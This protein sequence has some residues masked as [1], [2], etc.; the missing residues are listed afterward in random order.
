MPG[1]L[2][3]DVQLAVVPHAQTHLIVVGTTVRKPANIV[4]A[5][6][7]SLAWQVKPAQVELTYAFVDDGSPPDTRALLNAFVAEHGGVVWDAEPAPQQDF[8]DTGSTHQWTHQA[9]ARVGRSKDRILDW[10]RHQRAEAVWFC[11]SDLICDPMT[12]V[13]L[14]SV[15]EPIVAAVYWTRWEQ[16]PPEHPVVH[17]GPQV[18]LTHPYNLNGLGMEEWEFRRLLVNRQVVEVLG[19]GACTLIRRSALMKGVSFA[20]WPGNTMEGIGQ[21]EDRHFNLRA[22]ALHLKQ[23]ADPWPDIFHIYHR[24][25]DEQRIP[26][27]L[28][29]LARYEAR[30]TATPT[31]ETVPSVGDLVSLDL[32]ALEPVQTPNGLMHP[33]TRQVRGR[34]GQLG[35]HPE[36]EDALLQMQ[37]GQVVIV[38]VHF[39]LDYPFGPY[40]GQRRLIRVTL[41]DHKPNGYAPVIEEELIT[42]TAGRAIDMTTMPPDLIGLMREAHA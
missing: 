14:W 19:Q 31:T 20:P 34:L 25:Q 29:R 8:H 37:R 15:P 24:P 1:P 22:T 40:R 42:N 9:M 13:S 11:D 5:W 35:L 10:G 18:W 39:G 41:I 16:T 7:Q 3:T 21:G 28:R 17:A 23:V 6:L 36:I 30:P 12:L 32:H 27:M 33:P 26:E 2:A 38:P 4:A